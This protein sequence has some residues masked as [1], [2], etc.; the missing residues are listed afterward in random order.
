MCVG[1]GLNKETRESTVVFQRIKI[2]QFSYNLIGSDTSVSCLT[3]QH[4]QCHPATLERVGFR[5]T[6]N[7]PSNSWEQTPSLAEKGTT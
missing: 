7:C 4:P 3:E 2:H 1:W 5:G 6:R